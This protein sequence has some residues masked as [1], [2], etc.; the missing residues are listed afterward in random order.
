MAEILQMNTAQDVKEAANRVIDSARDKTEKRKFELEKALK[1]IAEISPTDGGFEEFAVML[2]LP[3][4]HFQVL[5]P[6]FLKELEKGYHNINDQMTMV[7]AMNL[8]GIRAEDARTEYIKICQ[9]IDDQLG[10]TLSFPKRDFLKQILGMTYNAVAE[11]EGASKRTILIPIEYCHSDAKMPTYAHLT[12]SGM[13]IYALEDI[14]IAPGETKLVPTGIKV[15]IPAGYE[16]QVRPKSGRCLKTKLRIANTPG[17]IDAGYRDEIGVIVDNIEPFIK[18]AKI[19]ENGRLYEVLFGSSYT[20]GKGEKFAQ[21]V[22]CEVP[23]AVFYQ[24]E[25]V[26]DITNDG[27]N[28]GFGSTGVK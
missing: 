17:T 5:A 10:E 6:I 27:R 23:K 26:S 16:L 2:S 22:L 20:I 24:V 3:D 8:A 25:H 4:E 13:D 18:E 15:A 14:T 28:G 1:Q 21:L 9:Q 12:D 7:Q 19:D 11:A